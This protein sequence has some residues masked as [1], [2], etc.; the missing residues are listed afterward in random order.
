MLG[1]KSTWFE[2]DDTH[3]FGDGG[4]E[5]FED[6]EADGVG[7]EVSQAVNLSISRVVGGRHVGLPVQ[8]HVG[9]GAVPLLAQ[10]EATGDTD[11]FVDVFDNL[12]QEGGDG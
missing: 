12:C 7:V 8:G 5:V 11:G 4:K 9:R 3:L 1:V 6:F 2:Q 10:N